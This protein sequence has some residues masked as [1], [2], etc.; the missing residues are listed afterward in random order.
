MYYGIGYT[1]VVVHRALTY[2]GYTAV[3]VH[4]APTWY[5]RVPHHQ[6]HFTSLTA[7]Y[8]SRSKYILWFVSAVREKQNSTLPGFLMSQQSISES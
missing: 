4:R 3:V 7:A 5:M 1:A 6:L 2:I 8:L